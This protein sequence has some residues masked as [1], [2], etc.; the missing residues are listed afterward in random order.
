MAT[1][2]ELVIP[3]GGTLAGA[4]SA[5]WAQARNNL[6]VLKIQNLEAQRA[7]RDKY[8]HELVMKLLEEKKQ[9]YLGFLVKYEELDMLL[10]RMGAREDRSPDETLDVEKAI[11]ELH[12]SL[13]RLYFIASPEA[14]Q[15]ADDI[16]WSIIQDGGQLGPLKNK[17]VECAREDLRV[18]GDVPSTWNLFREEPKSDSV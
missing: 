11:E 17:F 13:M 5:T 9:E 15:V 16:F 14:L 10:G 1:W 3:V 8:E 6:R 18:G 2:W 12:T 4:L 7:D